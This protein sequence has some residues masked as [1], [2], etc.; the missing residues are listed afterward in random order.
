MK[1]SEK[2]GGG[3]FTPHPETEGTVKGVIVDLTPLKLR[4]TQYGERE[5]FR[6]VYETE[7]V[8]E[9]GRRFCMWSRGY[10]PSLHEKATFRKDL[11]KIMGRDL[12]QLERDEFDTEGLIGTP[13]SLIIQHE[14]AQNG[15]TYSTISFIG[16][17]KSGTAITSSGNYKR[18]KDRD[19]APAAAAAGEQAGYKKA[20]AAK[21][22]EGRVDWQK[23]KVHV[24]AHAGVDL[25][26]LAEDAVKALIA[27]WLPVGQAL[28]KPLKADRELIAAL[29][30]VKGYL[31]DD[32]APAE[33]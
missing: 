3:E 30:E 29:L 15:Q 14:Q 28:P 10:S 21:A 9:N 18:V 26:D 23:V 32:S 16:P 2:K 13:V 12:T 6:I 33:Y 27:K 19:Q 20:P 31:G 7:V 8:D 25:G 17:H 4:T 5:E 11:K 22:D 24:G 1:L